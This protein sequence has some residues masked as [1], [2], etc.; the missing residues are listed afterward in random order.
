MKNKKQSKKA[1][2]TKLLALEPRTTCYA[3]G[4]FTEG[5]AGCFTT[6]QTCISPV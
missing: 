4:C 5:I 2:I 3:P 6:A 1:L